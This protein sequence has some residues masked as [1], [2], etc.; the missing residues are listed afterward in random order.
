MKKKLLVTVCVSVMTF[1]SFTSIRSTT[2]VWREL[3]GNCEALSGCEIFITYEDE[4]ETHTVATL[5]CEGD[6]GICEASFNIPKL[7]AKILDIPA[8]KMTLRCPGTQVFPE[9]EE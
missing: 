8:G 2:S 4:G 7:V 5:I 6:E 1:L 9:P 3:K